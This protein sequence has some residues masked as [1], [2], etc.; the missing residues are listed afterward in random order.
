MVFDFK[1]QLKTGDFVLHSWSSFPGKTW[2]VIQKQLVVPKVLCP[3]APSIHLGRFGCLAWVSFN[4]PPEISHS[5]SA[6]STGWITTVLNVAEYDYLWVQKDKDLYIMA[7]NR[8]A[9]IQGNEF[10]IILDRETLSP[11]SSCFVLHSDSL[12]IVL[13]LMKSFYMVTM[14]SWLERL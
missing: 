3:S 8:I 1:G 2:L 9:V 11:H 13:N 7:A 12:F 10:Y 6:F 14:L 5:C 4:Y